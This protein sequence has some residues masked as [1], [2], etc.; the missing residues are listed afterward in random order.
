MGLLILAAG[1]LL[2]LFD[3]FFNRRSSVKHQSTAG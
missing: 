3:Y 1:G 2:F